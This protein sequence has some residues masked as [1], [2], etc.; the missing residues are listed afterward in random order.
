MVVAI[1]RLTIIE[2]RYLIM[3]KV[4][5]I[6]IDVKLPAEEIAMFEAKFRKEYKD[7]LIILPHYCTGFVTEIDDTE[8]KS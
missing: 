5:V 4:I 6:K 8:V 2:K 3:K 1:V 7:G